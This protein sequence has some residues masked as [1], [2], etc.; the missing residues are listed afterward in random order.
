MQWN[1]PFAAGEVRRGDACPRSTRWWRQAS[2]R[3]T[4]RWCTSYSSSLAERDTAHAL[5]V[6]E[7]ALVSGRDTPRIGAELLEELRGQFLAAVVP[8]LRREDESQASSPAL[9][10]G[11]QVPLFGPARSVRAMEV[12]GAALVAMR[13]ALDA[14]ITLEVAIVRLTHPEADDD[15]S[16]LLERI[17][18]LERRVQKLTAPVGVSTPPPRPHHLARQLRNQ[19]PPLFKLLSR[20]S[21]SPKLTPTWDHSRRWVLSASPRPERTNQVLLGRPPL[22]HRRPP[23]S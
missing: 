11:G 18:R 6:I 9:S 20:A 5:Q 22:H 17:E 13:D 14:R 10:G 12:L 16:A 7:R 8:G 21:R 23:G 19:R 3:T 2:W 15:S 4:V 1:P